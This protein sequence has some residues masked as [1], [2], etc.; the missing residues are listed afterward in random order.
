MIDADLTYDFEEILRF[1][2]ELDDG[3]QFVMGNRMKGIE[4]GAMPWVNR[5]IGNPLLSGFLNLLYRTKA[6]D[7]NIVL[8]TLQPIPTDDEDLVRVPVEVVIPMESLT[9]LPQGD[10]DYAGGFDVYVVVANKDGDMSDVQ[11]KSHQLR[12]PA[13]DLA[14]TKGK[15]YTY[16]LDL[17]MEK[18]LDKVSVG[19]V[20]NVSNSTGFASQQVLAKDL[21]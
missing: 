6:N 5:Y 7:L 13:I 12:V 19:V 4:P 20:D 10:T 2:H 18:G 15:V 8:K 11:R 14:K 9:L 17:L 1:V 3:A 16:T 21:R